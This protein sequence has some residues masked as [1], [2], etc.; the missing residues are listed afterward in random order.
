MFNKKNEEKERFYSDGTVEFEFT[1]KQKCIV[2]IKKNRIDIEFSGANS[3]ITKGFSGTKTMNLDYLI[4]VQFKAPGKATTGYIQLIFNG[5]Q[6]SQGL[7]NAVK[8]ED[9]IVFSSSELNLATDL[10]DYL[11]SYIF[12]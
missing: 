9:S 10:K 12:K 6:S 4:G 3:A 11:L 8:D 5:M 2:K 1:S 7:T